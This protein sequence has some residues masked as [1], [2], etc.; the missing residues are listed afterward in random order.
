MCTTSGGTD[1]VSD[2]NA[3]L[4]R[5][6]LPAEVRHKLDHAVGPNPRRIPVTITKEHSHFRKQFNVVFFQF[7]GQTST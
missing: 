6:D 2:T 5:M 1:G 7:P 4:A 3:N